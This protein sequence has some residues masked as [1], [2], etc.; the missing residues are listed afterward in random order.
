VEEW[1]SGA[2]ESLHAIED[3]RLREPVKKRF[4]D[5]LVSGEMDVERAAIGVAWWGTKGGREMVL[6]GHSSSRPAM[7]RG[8]LVSEEKSSRL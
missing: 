7:M 3:P 5:M 2:A 6:H 8:A 4:L 1:L